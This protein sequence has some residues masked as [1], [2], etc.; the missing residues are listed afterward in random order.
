[1]LS[2]GH[3]HLNVAGSKFLA[4]FESSLT[5]QWQY[6]SARKRGG[7]YS[8]VA[9]NHLSHFLLA[10]RSCSTSYKSAT[11]QFEISTDNEYADVQISRLGPAARPQP[12]NVD[13]KD[14]VRRT[15]ST[16]VLRTSEP[17]SQAKRLEIHKKDQGFRRL[18]LNEKGS[19]SY[20]WRE[21]L[22]YLE[23]CWV[24]GKI[25]KVETT[26]GSQKT[27]IPRNIRADCIER[28]AIWTR[29]SFYDY[30]VRLAFSTVDRLVA[31][32]IYSKGETHQLAV[33]KAL[34]DV[35]TDENLKYVFSVEAA[36][37]G[38]AFFFEHGRFARGRDFFG[39]LQELQR[40]SNSST[41]NIML[42][43]AAKN[44]D[45]FTF[46]YILRLMISCKVHPDSYTWLHLARA[47]QADDVRM[48]IVNRMTEKGLLRDIALLQ[49]V[50]ALVTP[51]M[52]KKHLESGRDSQYLLGDLDKRNQTRWRS[53]MTYQAIVEE[54]G[55][56]QSPQEA[57]MVLQILHKAGYKPSQGLLLLLA[58]QCAWTKAHELTT[59][60]LRLFRTEYKVPASRRIYDV[61]FKQAWRSRLYN[62]CRVLWVHACINGH[63]SFDMQQMVQE[64][65]CTKVGDLLPTQPRSLF[66]QETAG[67]VIT[68]HH[69]RIHQGILERLMPLWQKAERGQP[70][71]KSDTGLRRERD[72]FLRAMR[73]IVDKDLAAVGKY[74]TV[75]PLDETLAKALFADRQW[76]V[77]RA[78]KSVPLAC[79]YSQIIDVG[80]IPRGFPSS[81]PQS[82]RWIEAPGD[83]GQLSAIDVASEIVTD[84]SRIDSVD[85]CC[86]N[87]EMRSRPCM[88]P[89]SVRKDH[90]RARR[91]AGE[92]HDAAQEAQDVPP[93]T[94]HAHTNESSRLENPRI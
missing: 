85:P 68:G 13:T 48:M 90:L 58:R 31:K 81:T 30:A 57:L 25:K 33:C 19:W 27:R 60:I 55:V 56:R 14:L 36:N 22:L 39:R 37:V 84:M 18:L 52:V 3:V 38:L 26:H 79:K 65:L 92:H 6:L 44:Q 23:R 5:C 47:V 67:K 21:P 73:D 40:D 83:G 32:Q 75:K 46:T 43:A 82:P 64:S 15:N 35:F 76:G 16:R 71:D 87:P 77:H 94:S 80:L 59:D 93:S 34:E 69:G 4:S 50:I 20:D 53:P 45:L 78:L 7:Q 91:L 28:P 49:D 2:A 51:M 74:R 8:L 10:I 54:V 86:M 11:T 12:S 42:A 29:T 24:P 1:M 89:A 41:F 70:I 9:S 88:C 63:T 72:T 17:R 66:W 61:M 62:F